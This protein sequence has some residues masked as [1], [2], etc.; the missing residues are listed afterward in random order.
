[1]AVTDPPSAAAVT[2][3]G[4]PAWSLPNQNQV[5]SCT[6]PAVVGLERICGTGRYLT[7]AA[8]AEAGLGGGSGG[9]GKGECP[10]QGC[11][12]FGALSGRTPSTRPV[13]ELTSSSSWRRVSP[14]GNGSPGTQSA[15]ILGSKPTV[16]CAVHISSVPPL[17]HS[18]HGTYT[19]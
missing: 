9:G 2:V 16:S 11:P 4:T 3:T 18:S 7:A 6:K 12:T 10:L 5:P 17:T 13:V 8:Q 1:M 19:M 15:G 14:S